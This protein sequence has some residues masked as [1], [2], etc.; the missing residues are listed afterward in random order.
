VLP[1]RFDDFVAAAKETKGSWWP[2]WIAWL[3]PRSGPMVE[4]RTPGSG[5]HA[6]IED[7]PGRYVKER[8]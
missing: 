8:I 1:E 7:A 3:A 5:K 4:A 2:D 6:I